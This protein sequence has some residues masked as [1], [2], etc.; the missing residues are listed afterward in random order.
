MNPSLG[1]DIAIIH[2]ADG[3]VVVAEIED[4]ADDASGLTILKKPLQA[5]PRK[6]GENQVIVQLLPYLA[7]AGTLPAFDVLPLPAHAIIT[8]REATEEYLKLYLEATSGIHIA[9]S[10]PPD[11]SPLIR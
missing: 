10:L 11:Q 9:S 7:F 1:K 8:I 4:D 2:M 3:A 6:A 5:F